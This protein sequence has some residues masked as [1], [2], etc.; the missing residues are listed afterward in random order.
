MKIT[1]CTVGHYR[2]EIQLSTTLTTNVKVSN[3]LICISRAWSQK[4]ISAILGKV[5]FWY[6]NDPNN[7]ENPFF[8]VS[9][10]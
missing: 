2:S 1:N 10:V 9:N 8:K 4:V 7:T 5:S 3:L 6:Q